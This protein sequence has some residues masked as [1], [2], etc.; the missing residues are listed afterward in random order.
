METITK[1]TKGFLPEFVFL[2]DAIL[3]ADNDVLDLEDMVV[4]LEELG[5][6]ISSRTLQRAFDLR[7]ALETNTYEDSL[8]VPSRKTLDGL[9]LFY[10]GGNPGTFL[11]LVQ[12][13]HGQLKKEEVLDYY[14]TCTPSDRMIKQVFDQPKKIQLRQ[15]Y[16]EGLELLLYELQYKSLE[17]FVDKMLDNRFKELREKL[18]TQEL[19]EELEGYI[20]KRLEEE[21]K[22]RKRSSFIYRILGGIALFFMT[23]PQF[24]DLKTEVLSAFYD[25]FDETLDI[26]EE[27]PDGE[28]KGDEPFDEI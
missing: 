22:K 17:S 2:T 1:L 10:Y 8:V 21:K 26:T 3:Q 13:K 11:E 7:K 25:D 9:T 24:D 6:K 14:E 28:G 15:E 4:A 19:K 18:G 27:R 12:Y 16:I 23:T 5:F 20:E